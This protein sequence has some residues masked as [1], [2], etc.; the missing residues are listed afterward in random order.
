M[1]TW[2]ALLTALCL[3]ALLPGCGKQASES[4]AQPFDPGVTVQALADGG[5][6]TEEL[7]QLEGDV[8]FSLYGLADQGL[9]RTALTGC[10]VLRSAGASCEEA[11][12]LV[13]DDAA[14]AEKGEAALKSYLANQIEANRDYRP[15][16]LPKLEKAILE[17]RDSSL[18]LVVAG[19]L[20][21][22]QAALGC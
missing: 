2:R 8:A 6:F 14:A 1:K 10:R 17:R 3:L 18:L 22:A 7:E 15:D 12:V 16:E 13:F 4:A 20:D 5:A 19:D 11:A 9:D 21:A